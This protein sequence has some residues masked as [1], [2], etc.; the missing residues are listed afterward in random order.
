MFRNKIIAIILV[1]LLV[2]SVIRYFL[3]VETALSKASLAITI[4]TSFLTFLL[5]LCIKESKNILKNNYLKIGFIFSISFLVVHF[6]EYLGYTIGVKE[7]LVSSGSY[8]LK[9][10]NESAICSSCAYI[11]F[12]LGYVIMVKRSETLNS[13]KRFT[14]FSIV[15]LDVLMIV[16]VFLFYFF[17]DKQYFES[18]GNYYILNNG[19]L[20]PLASISQVTFLGTQAAYSIAKIKEGKSISF[21]KYPFSFSKLYYVSLLFY[22]ILLLKSGDR[23][24]ILYVIISYSLPYFINKRKKLKLRMAIAGIIVGIIGLNFLGILRNLSGE[25][26]YE[27]IGETNAKMQDMYEGESVL[28]A[29]TEQLSNVVRAYNVVYDFTQNNGTIKGL[30]FLNNLIGFIPGLRSYV[31]YPSL[32]VDESTLALLST[33][34]LS[35][36]LLNSDHGM[37]TT[38][39]GDTYY[40]FGFIGTIILFFIFGS[41][42]RKF[43][44]VIFSFEDCSLF[45]YI[46]AFWYFIFAIYIGRSSLLVPLSYCGYTYVIM[47]L[48]KKIYKKSFK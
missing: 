5:L 2:I 12:I 13:K 1:T 40:N 9:H 28:F 7:F 27:K 33:D 42:I 37:G 30:G 35:T 36:L 47:I 20:S 11:S 4:I 34:S 38:C 22:I 24:P 39:V 44:N 8:Q 48:S 21:K 26:S 32:G 16:S 23:G 45:V 31:I 25:L 41:V 6:F 10:V 29:S 19:G 17:A 46:C 15:F 18:G 14:S 43:D 3:S